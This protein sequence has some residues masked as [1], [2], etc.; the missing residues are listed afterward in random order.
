MSLA[1]FTVTFLSFFIETLKK[2]HLYFI[3]PLPD[4]FAQNARM[5]VLSK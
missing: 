3:A 1:F 2:I 5:Y 4:S